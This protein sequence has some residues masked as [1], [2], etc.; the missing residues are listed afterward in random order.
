MC[1]K[2]KLI[3]AVLYQKYFVIREE[4]QNAMK[5]AKNTLGTWNDIEAYITVIM[6]TVLASEKRMEKLG[7]D[8]VK[9]KGYNSSGSTFPS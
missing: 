9:D 7:W 3:Y 6:S 1:C 8:L 4:L 5:D 2:L